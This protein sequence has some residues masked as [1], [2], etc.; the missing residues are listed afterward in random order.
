[1]SKLPT[2][3]SLSA[4]SLFVPLFIWLLILL[5]SCASLPPN[6]DRSATF[7]FTDTVNT[8][9]GKVYAEF[10]DD[11]LD[12]SGFF[13]LENGLDAFT[14]RLILIQQADRS[15]DV[16]YYMIHTDLTGILFM[17]ELLQ[18]ADRGVRVRLLI[19][20]MDLEGRDA[21]LSLL[22]THPNIDL[23]VFNP[24]SRST[25]RV[26][27]YI[28]RFGS[29]TRRM[30]NKSITVDN[31]ISVVGGRN[32]GD[33]YFDANPS[34]VFGDLDVL[35]IGPVVNEVSKS[36]DQ[37]WNNERAYPIHILSPEPVDENALEEGR[38]RLAEYLSRESVAE[39]QNSLLNSG[40]AELIKDDA[41]IFYWGTGDVLS[42]DPEKLS[43]YETTKQYSL[44]DQ[45]S[46]YFKEI[47]REFLI[48]S[49][50]FVPGKRGTKYLT[51]L[52]R[53]GVR[54]RI[55]TNSLSSTDVGLVHAGYSKYRRTLLRA[56]VELYEVNKSLSKE[57]LKEREMTGKKGSKVSLH[58]K[59]FVL[60]RERIF[61]GSLN[62]DPRSVTENTEIGIMLTS[63]EVA[64]RMVDIF[65]M[66][67]SQQTFRLELKT[68]DDG[69]ELISWHGLK[70]GKEHTWSF[71]PFT[72][73]FQ[74]F[75]IG[76]AG[77]LPIE[78]QL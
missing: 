60:D 7:A 63:E 16:Q 74:R 22:A 24:F 1:L 25:Y 5:N 57:G 56:G 71:D 34:L 43:S 15:I 45:L 75:V 64:K 10:K 31:Q 9:F 40:F 33:E 23:R 55:I 44:A 27:Q 3:I 19:D 77:L 52:S 14:A 21:G 67:A 76:L 47:K 53:S 70:D 69:L 59:S 62:F 38:S 61:I 51:D 37:Y 29:V 36:F 6:S 46:P 35:A 20:D 49:P 26:V 8:R 30:H 72:G 66:V 48:F 28:S 17:N 12:D 73:F 58:A 54:V 11:Q 68:A 18:A 32:I 41:L 13:L 42:D 4:S 2:H 50:Y 78:S 39:Y 65:D